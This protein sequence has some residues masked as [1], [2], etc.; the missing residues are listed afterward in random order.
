M[1][2]AESQE[3]FFM[4]A[5]IIRRAVRHFGINLQIKSV[6]NAVHCFWNAVQKQAIMFA[7]MRNVGIKSSRLG[8]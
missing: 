3:R 8:G 2:N 4:V 7:Q 1:L 5:A 6:L